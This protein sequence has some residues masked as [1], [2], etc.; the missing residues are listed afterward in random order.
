MLLAM[1]DVEPGPEQ[2]RSLVGAALDVNFSICGV[3]TNQLTAGVLNIAKATEGDRTTKRRIV[4][5]FPQGFVELDVADLS[6]SIVEGY[7]GTRNKIDVWKTRNLVSGLGFLVL[8]ATETQHTEVTGPPKKRFFGTE[9]PGETRQVVTQVSS[10]YGAMLTVPLLRGLDL[11]L[12]IFKEPEHESCGSIQFGEAFK[13][14][15][16][17]LTT[18]KDEQGGNMQVVKALSSLLTP[19]KVTGDFNLD[20]GV[21]VLS[22]L[23][24]D[25]IEDNAHDLVKAYSFVL[26][27]NTHKLFER[28]T[29]QPKRIDNPKILEFKDSDE[30]RGGYV[31]FYYL[32]TRLNCDTDLGVFKVAGSKGNEVYTFCFY[33]RNGEVLIPIV[34]VVREGDYAEFISEKSDSENSKLTNLEKLHLLSLLLKVIDSDPVSETSVEAA[35][36][37]NNG[38]SLPE[39]FDDMGLGSF[40]AVKG[41]FEKESRLKF[42]FDDLSDSQERALLMLEY[43]NSVDPRLFED[44][45][46]SFFHETTTYSSSRRVWV[47][48]EKVDEAYQVIRLRESFRYF[49]SRLGADKL[50]AEYLGEKEPANEELVNILCRLKNGTEYHG[51]IED[52]FTGDGVKIACEGYVVIDRQEGATER[53][54]MI[55]IRPKN[56]ESDNFARIINKQF[57]PQSS[58]L[59]SLPTGREAEEI[60]TLVQAFIR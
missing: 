41:M 55:Y 22:K 23:A 1:T 12:A 34:S 13:K 24:G 5:D 40:T 4:G 50:L 8:F 49:A 20:D 25:A 47:K 53:T 39:S 10:I 59:K 54:V 51:E 37:N 38:E 21:E 29:N 16:T 46:L 19:E 56:Y 45:F 7:Q 15:D 52:D 32:S 42:D 48:K 30:F 33:D 17:I 31:D 35:I 36:G 3:L 9:T 6:A 43:I 58:T 14:V 18:A 44:N 11:P 2:G 26:G 28:A 27:E 60:M 57:D